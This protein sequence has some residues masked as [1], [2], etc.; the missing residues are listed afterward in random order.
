MKVDASLTKDLT[1]AAADARA[2]EASG[3]DGVWVGETKHDPF[4][5]SLRAADATSR[6]TVGTSI[7]IAF[8][9]T[10]DSDPAL[11]ADVRSALHE[12]K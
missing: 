10:Y 7:A 5:L 6:I 2:I 4:L 1:Q 9:R 3:Y 11:W 8:A 12:N